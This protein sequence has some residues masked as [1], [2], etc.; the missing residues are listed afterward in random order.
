MGARKLRCTLA[1]VTALVAVLACAPVASAGTAIL[2][3]DGTVAAGQ[4][5]PYPGGP[6]H[7]LVDEAVTQPT[8][9][10]T[11]DDLIYTSGAGGG[12]AE[13]SV[14]TSALGGE[15]VTRVTAW[16]H[17]GTGPNKTIRM[18]LVHGTTVLS[19]LTVPGGST[20]AWRQA[21][22]TV[23]LTQAQVDNLRVRFVASGAS[24][25]QV[26]ASYIQL[27][28]ALPPSPPSITGRPGATGQDQTPT[29][30]F[31]AGAGLG[32]ECRLERPGFV[33]SNWTSC[34]SPRTYDLT[35]QPDA[36][37]TF[38][39]RTK[40]ADGV[41]SSPVADVYALDTTDPTA[42]TFT[43]APPSPSADD[44]PSWSFG[45]EPGATYEC[46]LRR[47]ASVISAFAP[48]S[49]P[50]QYDLS[51]QAD[52]TYTFAVRAT[53]VA[54][55]TGPESTS[56]YVLN[57]AA[58]GLPT[59]TL[60]GVSP[61]DDPLP[62]FTF[63]A[64][65]AATYECRFTEGARVLYDWTLCGSPRTEDLTFELDGTYTMAVRGV[66]ATSVAGPV[67]TRDYVYDTTDPGPP[68]ISP[69][70]PLASANPNPEW[71][72]TGESGVQFACQV[73][74]GAR[75]VS[76]R[77]PCTSP[78]GV[79]LSSEPDGTYTF[80][81]H[82]IDAAGNTSTDATR[83]YALDRTVPPAPT[84]D[85]GPPATGSGRALS[86]DFSG[87]GAAAFECRL[88]RP[89]GTDVVAWGTCSSPFQHT[90]GAGEPDGDYVFSV[91][92]E[93]GTG[94]DGPER[95]ATYDLDTAKPAP[96]VLTGQPA[97][98]SA[99]PA[100]QW[101]F[102]AEAG[103]VVECRL[104]RD[105]VLISDWAECSSPETFDL[106]SVP[107]GTYLFEVRATDAALNVGDPASGTYALDRSVPVQPDIDSAPA[108]PRSNRT[109][110]WGFSS[111][112][113]S[114]ECR[115]L[116]PDASPVEDWTACPASPKSYT[117]D[118]LALD[119]PYTFE[120]RGVSVTNVRGPEASGTYVLDTGLP[121]APSIGSGPTS[122]T[123]DDTPTWSF[124]GEPGASFECRLERG[125]VVEFDWA[126]CT[127]AH[128][129]DL[130]SE[131]DGTYDF[132]VR[133][134]DAA[135]NAGPAATATFVLDRAQPPAPAFDS[136]PGTRGSGRSPQWAFS[137]PGASF[138]CRVN[139]AAWSA[140]VSPYTHDLV[141]Q[142]D[143]TYTFQAR[144]VSATGVPGLVASD[145]YELD[146][147]APGAPAITSRPG[148]IGNS[149]AVL[150]GFSAEAGATVS[151]RLE[152]GGVVEFDWI[153]CSSPHG[154]DL[155]GKPDGTYTFLV[156][157]ADATGNLGP[158]ASDNYQLDRVAPGAPSI[159]S[160]PGPL[161][162]SRAPGWT[163]SGEAGATF[164]CRLERGAGTVVADWG[165]CA[166]PRTW[167]LVGAPD[168][169]HTFV[170]RAVDAAGNRGA[171]S[172]S[173]YV[174]DTTP[175]ALKIDTG[176]PPLG[177]DRAPAWTFAGET[178]ARYECRLERDGV[179]VA[180][181]AACSSPHA[182][183]LAGL[184]DGRYRFVARSFDAA[185]NVS[186]EA[187]ATYDL[188]TMAPAAPVI[189][190]RP[191]SPGED[192]TPTW[193]FTGETGARFD[194]RVERG[195]VASFDWAPCA[196]PFTA[197]LADAHEGTHEFRVRATDAA[198]NTGLPSRGEYVLRLPEPAPAPK[199]KLPEPA[200]QPEPREEPAP[201]LPPP[202]SP[203]A[204][205][206]K[207]PAPV[208]R[209][210][211]PKPKPRPAAAAPKA[212]PTP[213]PAAPRPAPRPKPKASPVAKVGK[214]LGKGIKAAADVVT[215]HPDKS[216]FPASLIFLVLGFLA[217][218]NRI[219]RS[220]P[221]L[222]LAPVHADPDLEFLPPPDTR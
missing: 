85:G 114:H 130:S 219:D 136:T 166:S 22:S 176:P 16:A 206:K 193:R 8:A 70:T 34:L 7:S 171:E 222:A 95:T 19:T 23:A 49:T 111:A 132:F 46:E 221:K 220:D 112:A 44:A 45:G 93:S 141:G 55:N 75:V 175:G 29:W 153:T 146:T 1:C 30:T 197:D 162:A 216:V 40:N 42:P 58:P 167:D 151:C 24:S 149:A 38:S 105:G 201:A 76:A 79:D 172:R 192:R 67:A 154:Y 140:C 36:T 120:V 96:P 35:L 148:A 164:E 63:S 41:T 88:Q 84:I 6:L 102:E 123:A 189:E 50:Q 170:V 72:F 213:K 21:T 179:E 54:L 37:Y 161:G 139:G 116:A 173:G 17:V 113:P 190:G 182:A 195:G 103:A 107:D 169:Q 122:P 212:A 129:Y 9:P 152:R 71:S 52:G 59:V 99:D 62:S 108:S 177:R 47:G 10:N 53:D 165:G 43:S 87:A 202:P 89:D 74:E 26:F 106:A 137:G 125:G 90:L 14:G 78:S 73:A 2:R 33:V 65:G 174:L 117:L 204:P 82:A 138:E 5:M 208:V 12:T 188:D 186:A 51:A 210:P 3:P 80:S 64:T 207:M 156:R 185:G 98:P 48:C 150:W 15:Y 205:K 214:V 61:D 13:L 39:V 131:S 115:L 127:S 135:L 144:A 18:E 184:P 32:T 124:T 157:A 218:Q 191:E 86:W 187:A 110:A 11:V 128:T 104:Q 180:P 159:D 81:V 145:A 158:T 118:P 4:W 194:C 183:A 20:N 142:N 147:A 101:A 28:T 198:G 100:P 200:P 25:G 69:S 168:G 66:S 126:A 143:G 134:R 83:T 68:V 97:S 217:V 155:S 163:F 31:T 27:D 91:R 57:R 215:K 199:P 109:I 94:V 119:G 181:W 203:P 209:K 121:A 178:A 160:G 77:G 196:S 60:G 211:A 92:G 133:A 56:T